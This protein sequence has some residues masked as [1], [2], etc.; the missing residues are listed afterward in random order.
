MVELAWWDGQGQGPPKLRK[1]WVPVVWPGPEGTVKLIALGDTLSAV[2]SHWWEGHTLPCQA[3][4]CLAC[5]KGERSRLLLYVPCWH[6]VWARVVLACVSED[7]AAGALGCLAELD[8]LRGRWLTLARV[9]RGPRSRV[10]LAVE[11]SVY[12]GPLP[13]APDVAEVLRRVWGGRERMMRADRMQASADNRPSPVLP[14]RGK[15]ADC[16]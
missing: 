14:Y 9:G 7:A 5:H 8:A 2:R 12:D 15:E 6:V 1:R 16:G 13:K 4:Q 10:I 3:D 11:D